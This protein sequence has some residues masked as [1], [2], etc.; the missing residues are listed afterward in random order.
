MRI[1][2]DRIRNNRYTSRNKTAK[3]LLRD[4]IRYKEET[5]DINILVPCNS[6]TTGWRYAKERVDDNG[7]KQYQNSNEWKFSYVLE[8][9]QGLCWFLKFNNHSRYFSEYIVEARINPKIFAGLKDYIAA[10]DESFINSVVKRFDVEAAKISPILRI[11]NFY[12][13]NRIDFC[14]NFDL[15]EMGIKCTP[16]Q[17]IRLIKHGDCPPHFKIWKYYDTISHRTKT[18]KYSHYLKSG[19]VNINCY[20][21]YKQL[22]EVYENCPDIESALH[23]IRFEVQCKYRKTYQMQMNERKETNNPVEIFRRLLSDQVSRNMIEH[24]FYQIIKPG[25]YY[26]LKE[27]IRVI[28]LHDLR[29]ETE[30]VLVDTLTEINRKGI[31]KLRSELDLY[32]TQLL[33]RS[34]RKLAELG[35]NPVTI[36]KSYGVKCLPNLLDAFYRLRDSGALDDKLLPDPYEPLDE[37]FEVTDAKKNE[38]IQLVDEER[39][40]DPAHHVVILFGDE[41]QESFYEN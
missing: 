2:G 33:Y 9:R 37:P 5:G 8:H 28:E 14:V 1:L 16:E 39:E 4:F 20:Y 27:A 25:D 18:G 36:P 6:S 23:V 19:S 32:G 26:T 30:Q 24:Y 38:H 15:N 40:H 21:K 11:I 31:A 34:L 13:L 10:S 17:M 7:R 41:E 3:K 12:K 22:K 35:I 29:P